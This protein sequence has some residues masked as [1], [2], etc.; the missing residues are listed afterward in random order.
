MSLKKFLKPSKRKIALT[1]CIFFIIFF[2]E[3]LWFTYNTGIF[4]FFCSIPSCNNNELYSLPWEPYL[5]PF[6]P[7]G[8]HCGHPDFLT[9]I[10][11]EIYWPLY[12][13]GH[14]L[15][16]YLLS[17]LIVWIYDKIKVKKK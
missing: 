5:L 8:Y 6:A 7:C 15:I 1:A 12:I 14:I 4:G 17:C 3:G 16:S 11:I 13:I 10:I 2:A 9:S